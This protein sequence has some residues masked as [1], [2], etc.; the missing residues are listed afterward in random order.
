MKGV[1]EYAEVTYYS[2]PV[3]S[4]ALG[5]RIVFVTSRATRDGVC[6]HPLEMISS[7][8][9][10]R[11]HGWFEIDESTDLLKKI[12]FIGEIQPPITDNTAPK[13]SEAVAHPWI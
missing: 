4:A 10:E 13:T 11:V 7:S 3:C 8:P 1:D 2:R 6:G 5:V 9:A 12:G